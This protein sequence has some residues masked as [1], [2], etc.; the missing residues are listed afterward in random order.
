[1]SISYIHDEYFEWIY[2]RVMDTLEYSRLLDHLNEIL[3]LPEW[4]VG[5]ERIRQMDQNRI[6]DA[7]S[8]RYDFAYENGYSKMVID[9]VFPDNA[10]TV[11]ELMA[12]LAIRC[13]TDIMDDPDY[14]DRTHIWF[15]YMLTS[16]GLIDQ[17][18]DFYDEDYVIDVIQVFMERRY[19]REGAGGLFY[20]PDSEQDMRDLDLW[21]QMHA[22]LRKVSF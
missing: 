7:I 10:C 20:V 14:G 17:T 16:L 5:D 15:K 12:A 2:E 6:G 9:S 13:E 1:M 21:Y 22:F 11:L 18:N 19:S 8:L 4:R 3:Y